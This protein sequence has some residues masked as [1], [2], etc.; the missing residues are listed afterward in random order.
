MEENVL[1]LAICLG[2]TD[3]NIHLL[4][5]YAAAKLSHV[6]EKWLLPTRCGKACP[7]KP[8]LSCYYVIHVIEPAPFFDP[9]ALITMGLEE[10]SVITSHLNLQNVTPLDSTSVRG[11]LFPETEPSPLIPPVGEGSLCKELNLIRFFLF[12]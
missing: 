4:H 2:H 12:S 8:T 5:S 9:D 6:R 10:D 1:T 7:G 11:S 3:T